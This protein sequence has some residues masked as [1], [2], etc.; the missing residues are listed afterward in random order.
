MGDSPGLGRFRGRFWCV[1]GGRETGFGGSRKAWQLI[2][3]VGRVGGE[4]ESAHCSVC[5]RSY[6]FE[7]DV[8]AYGRRTGGEARGVKSG[9]RQT[10]ISER[11]RSQS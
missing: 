6:E 9:A 3:M 8:L 1:R 2:P 11:H 7:I 4:G 5:C 10:S